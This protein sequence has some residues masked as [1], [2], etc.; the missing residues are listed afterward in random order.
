MKTRPILFNG[1]MVLAI[2]AG[3]KTQ[4]RRAVN[5]QPEHPQFGN[6]KMLA[7]DDEGAELY[8]HGGPL[9][10]RAIRC[11]YGLPGDR[12]WI[13]EAW[14]SHIGPMGE[15]IIYAYRATDDDRL[16]PWRPSIHM[17]REASRITLEI[18]DVRVER[19]QD[20]SEDDARAEGFSVDRISDYLDVVERMDQ[21]ESRP[22]TCLYRD[23]WDEI[24]GDGAWDANPWVW[25]VSFKRITE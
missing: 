19:L 13:R 5:P 11:P 18:T 4:T 24:N 9:L 12:L 15:S 7:V 17:P 8:L 3:V 21:T 1:A 25:A 23:L 22:A 6:R 2:L 10:A 14:Q 16:G 20:I